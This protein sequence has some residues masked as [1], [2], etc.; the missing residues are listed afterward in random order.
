MVGEHANWM[1]F[2]LSSLAPNLTVTLIPPVINGSAA[3][4]DINLTCTAT[5]EESIASDKYQFIWLLNKTLVDIF[6]GRINVRT[7]K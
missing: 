6:D 2:I 7:Y 5:V 4:V 1:L 3:N